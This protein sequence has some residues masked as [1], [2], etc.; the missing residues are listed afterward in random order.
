MARYRTIASELTLTPRG[1]RAIFPFP[2]R[3]R[4]RR[5]APDEGGARNAS[6]SFPHP[7]LWRDLS[8]ERERR[9]QSAPTATRDENDIY[10]SST[11]RGV[12]VRAAARRLLGHGKAPDSN[13]SRAGI[14]RENTSRRNESRPIRGSHRHASRLLRGDRTWREE[15]HAQKRSSGSRMD[16]GCRY[17]RYCEISVVEP[18]SR[19]ARNAIASCLTTL[20]G[21]A[22]ASV[23]V[24]NPA[25]LQNTA[26]RG[27]S[28][29]R[30]IKGSVSR[31]VMPGSRF[32]QVRS[33][34]SNV[35][36]A[37]RRSA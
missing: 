30:K 19:A 31:L 34:H 6:K 10:K 33:S 27:S 7:R 5:A 4:R 17:R 37:S 21:N 2:A 29:Y 35:L 36:S 25:F 9:R 16:S 22:F 18:R 23:A 1:T 20:H 26:N 11:S 15:S 14:A 13:P 24:G 32:A 3:G 12:E 8:R 28:R